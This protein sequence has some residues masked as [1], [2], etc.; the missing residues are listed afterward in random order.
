MLYIVFKVAIFVLKYKQI[1]YRNKT[2]VECW[3]RNPSYPLILI[4]NSREI[5][6]SKMAV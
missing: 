4:D 2:I 1:L 3:G 5:N 6:T